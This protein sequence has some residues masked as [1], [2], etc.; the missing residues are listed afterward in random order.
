LAKRTRV[1][2]VG[3]FAA[4]REPILA[5][6]DGRLDE[7]F[8]L[9]ERFAALGNELGQPLCGRGRGVRLLL[10]PA[11]YLGRADMWLAASEEQRAPVLAA[12]LH[13]DDRLGIGVIG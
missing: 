5:I 10:A 6:V 11:L 7:A 13:G 1:A 8:V 2:T 3:L 4:Q 9:L 12:C